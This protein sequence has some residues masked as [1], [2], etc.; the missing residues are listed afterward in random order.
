MKRFIASVTERGQ[1]TL[2]AE[3]RRALGAK[4]RGKIIFELD[5]GQVRV[6]PPP[7]TLDEIYGSVEP[8]HRPE[9]FKEISRLAK[10]EHVAKVI[11]KMA[12]N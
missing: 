6:L 11:R 1:V 10:E 12:A 8:L 7:L 2:P 3:V 9:D 4:L 5:D